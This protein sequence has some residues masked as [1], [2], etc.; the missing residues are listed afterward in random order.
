M[1]PECVVKEETKKDEKKKGSNNV[2]KEMD[3]CRNVEKRKK[4][5]RVFDDR[6]KG[7]GWP[8][9]A[10]RRRL[11]LGAGSRLIRGVY[12]T[13]VVTTCLTVTLPSDSCARSS[14]SAPSSSSS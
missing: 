1:P 8:L 7:D 14:S 4:E 2:V 6:S 13:V 9:Y 11:P 5:N 12:V 10:T 3:I